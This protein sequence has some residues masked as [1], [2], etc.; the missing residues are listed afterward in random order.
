[1]ASIIGSLLGLDAPKHKVTERVSL[2]DIEGQFRSMSD[3]AQGVV[4]GSKTTALAS[5][6]LGGIVLAACLYFLGRRKGR[7]RSSVLEIRRV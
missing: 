4:Q 2:K 5:A 1:M 7:R 6:V 3:S